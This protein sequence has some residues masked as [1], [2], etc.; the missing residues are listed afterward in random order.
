SLAA[1][2]PQPRS[3]PFQT[4]LCICVAMIRL[5]M[6]TVQR[7]IVQLFSL[8]PRQR[9]RFPDTAR[10][11]FGLGLGALLTIV[12][13]EKYPGKEG[14]VCTSCFA[15]GAYGVARVSI[16]HT[17]RHRLIRNVAV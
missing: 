17:S 8:R 9:E 12:V 2:R 7:T 14:W 6:N 1:Q 16:A 15:A 4:S 3:A 10:V 11:F 5:A 13:R